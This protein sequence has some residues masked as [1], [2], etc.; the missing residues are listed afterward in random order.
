MKAKLV[1]ISMVSM[2]LMACN[3]IEETESDLP[4]VHQISFE[5]ID[6]KLPQ[7]NIEVDPESWKKMVSLP[8][9]KIYTDAKFNF[10]SHSKLSNAPVKLR[11]KGAASVEYSLKSLEVIFNDKVSNNRYHILP[12]SEYNQSINLNEL[13][14]I[15]LRNSGQDFTKTMLKDK[16][17]TMLADQSLLNFTIMQPGS[18]GQVFVNNTYYG[19]LNIRSESNLNSIATQENVEVDEVV[20]YKVDVDN[21]N[22]EFNEGNSKLTP[23]LEELIDNGNPTEISQWINE[24]SFIDYILFQDYIGNTD[25]PHNNIRMFSKN[26]EPFQ[27]ILYDLDHASEKTKNPLLPELEYISH[28]LGKIYRAY[29]KVDG[30]DRRLEERQAELYE[31]WSPSRFQNIV[32]ELSLIIKDDIPFQIAKHGFP[33]SKYQWNW[34][35]EK[36]VRD[37]E[38]RDYYIRDKYKLD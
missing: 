4:D 6:S 17:L 5:N 8:H 14:N 27:F 3:T 18:A 11:I 36:M 37:F 21:G 33:E 20:I 19:M 35:I 22:I 9:E 32:S 23:D 7:I 15:R 24:S 26:G 25:W 13:K 12:N 38:R 31:F 28:D 16:A 10:S 34:E 30:F 1:F 2:F 29:R